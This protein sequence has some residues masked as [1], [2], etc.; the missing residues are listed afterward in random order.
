MP[1][2]SGTGMAKHRR[3]K[4]NPGTDND[5]V[6][7]GNPAGERGFDDDFFADSSIDLTSDAKDSSDSDSELDINALLRKYMPEYQDE[8]ADPAAEPDKQAG[9]SPEPEEKPASSDP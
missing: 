8:S 1:R 5:A 6:L 2:L 7:G 3:K 9:E 4:G